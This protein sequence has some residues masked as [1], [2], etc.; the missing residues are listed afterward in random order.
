MT[1]KRRRTRRARKGRGRHREGNGAGKGWAAWLDWMWPGG[2][3]SAGK[4]ERGRRTGEREREGGEST[5]QSS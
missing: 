5:E 1:A 3:L 2:N 4:R